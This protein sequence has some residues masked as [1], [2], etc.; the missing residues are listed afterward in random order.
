MNRDRRHL[1][2]ADMDRRIYFLETGRDLSESEIKELQIL[3]FARE[4]EL[5][6]ATNNKVTSK[7]KRPSIMTTGL[8]RAKV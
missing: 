5:K 3:K 2:M 4:G 1:E 8:D 7:P 6:R